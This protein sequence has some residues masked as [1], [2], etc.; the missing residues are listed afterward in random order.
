MRDLRIMPLNLN[1]SRVWPGSFLLHVSS[2]VMDHI[3][4]GRCRSIGDIRNNIC[5]GRSRSRSSFTPV[6]PITVTFDLEPGNCIV[7]LHATFPLNVLGVVTDDRAPL[8]VGTGI[9][10]FYRWGNRFVL[11]FASR[12]PY[13]FGFGGLGPDVFLLSLCRDVESA[14]DGSV[15]LRVAVDLGV[16][17]R[18]AQL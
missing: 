5:R 14:F 11:A 8:D 6:A 16:V 1:Q 15:Y 9:T 13:F 10:A 2:L 7:L 4:R 3:C 12:P 17:I 18:L